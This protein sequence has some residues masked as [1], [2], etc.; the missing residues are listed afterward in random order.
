M[1]HVLLRLV[2]SAAE[3]RALRIALDCGIDVQARHLT[4]QTAITLQSNML[5]IRHE[6]LRK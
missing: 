2:L 5:N 6:L 1:R 4:D 3:R